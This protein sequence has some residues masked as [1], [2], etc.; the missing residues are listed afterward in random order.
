MLE[1]VKLYGTQFSA[2]GAVLVFIFGAYKYF[3]ERKQNHFWKEFETYHK[4]IKELVEPTVPNSPMYMDRQAAVVFELRFFKRYYP[5]SLRM[6]EGLRM[7][8]NKPP[9]QYPRLINEI[10]LTIE[11]IKQ[12]I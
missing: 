11:H 6:L 5:H 10:D 2:I 8:W 1:L 3:S 7:A 12:K 9:S 4:L